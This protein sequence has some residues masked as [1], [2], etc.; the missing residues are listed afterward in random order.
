MS[1][2]IANFLPEAAYLMRVPS[3]FLDFYH[4]NRQLM[5]VTAKGEIS[6]A[7]DMTIDEAK[8]II[9]EILKWKMNL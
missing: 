8:Y 5:T 3:D 4:A 9:Q 2:S 6:F 7:S 1:E